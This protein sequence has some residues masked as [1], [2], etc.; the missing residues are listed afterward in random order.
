MLELR[1]DEERD[2]ALDGQ[3]P[4]RLQE[5]ED[6]EDRAERVDPP[7]EEPGQ[8]TKIFNTTSIFK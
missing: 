1:P 5:P 3:D 2:R 7:R 8:E 4:Q 6:E